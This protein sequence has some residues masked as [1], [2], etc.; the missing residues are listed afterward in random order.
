MAKSYSTEKSHA[1]INGIIDKAVKQFEKEGLVNK[2][3]RGLL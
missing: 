2:S 3:G 1:F